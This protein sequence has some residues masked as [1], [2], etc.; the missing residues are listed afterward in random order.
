MMTAATVSLILHI[1]VPAMSQTAD[2]VEID[3]IRFQVGSMADS[4]KIV[5]WKVLAARNGIDSEKKL[6][7]AARNNLIKEK[8]IR[9]KFQRVE[10]S[11]V[12]AIDDAEETLLSF[13]A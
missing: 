1:A 10:V 12:A 11:G 9:F 4:E 13:S 6:R 2:L 7:V 3:G 5:Q 8:R